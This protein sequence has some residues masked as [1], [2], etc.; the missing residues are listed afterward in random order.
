MTEKTEQA[1]DRFGFDQIDVTTKWEAL[2]GLRSFVDGM[3]RAVKLVGG[4]MDGQVVDGGAAHYVEV[5]AFGEIN[6]T[7][8]WSPEVSE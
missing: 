1:D 3:P 6:R 7:A 8:I 4:P 2:R 5:T